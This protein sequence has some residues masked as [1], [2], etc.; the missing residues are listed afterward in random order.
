MAFKTVRYPGMVEI[1]DP[2]N[3][4]AFQLPEHHNATCVLASGG[5]GE[6]RVLVA[7]KFLGQTCQFSLTVDGG[8]DVVIT[9][10]STV[11]QTG[12][13][14]MTI[15]DA[16]DEITLRGTVKAGALVWRVASNDGVAL[17]TV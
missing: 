8:G 14:T 9:A 17:T 3:A 12:D 4:G 11:N 7:P 15:A 13:N 1:K 10:A 5:S 2:G 6:T 16:G